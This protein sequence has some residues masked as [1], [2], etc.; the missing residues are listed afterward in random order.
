MGALFFFNPLVIRLPSP[1]VVLILISSSCAIKPSDPSPHAAAVKEPNAAVASP[2]VVK[3]RTSPAPARKPTPLFEGLFSSNTSSAPAPTARPA[4]TP[5]VSAHTSSAAAPQRKTTPLFEGLFHAD[6]TSKPATTSTTSPVVAAK[7]ASAPTP[8]RKTT[9]LFSG[10]FRSNKASKPASVPATT[11]AVA[12]N[13]TS[14]P[15]PPRK[16]TPLFESLFPSL[17]KADPVQPPAS[18]AAPTLAKKQSAREK[19]PPL[20]KTHGDGEL[21]NE[22]RDP[23]V[24]NKLDSEHEETNTETNPP[25]RTNKPVVIKGSDS[26]PEIPRSNSE[27]PKPPLPKPQIPGDSGSPSGN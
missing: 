14:S 8:P 12:A 3:S 26:A 6:K 19:T 4:A 21:A 16:P 17:R 25:A 13:P 18:A 15:T 24:L 5:A 27:T 20:P 11:P 10:F 2:A 1:I 7:T 9:P 22:L 23:N